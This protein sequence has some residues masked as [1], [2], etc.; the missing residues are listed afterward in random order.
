MSLLNWLPSRL[1]A[2]WFGLM[3][4]SGRRSEDGGK[5]GHGGG[6]ISLNLLPNPHF[7]FANPL[8]QPPL[9][10][11]SGDPLPPASFRL[12]VSPLFCCC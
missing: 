7:L 3:G 10:L 8:L 11:Q 6:G 2:N 9:S 5:G 12:E 4:S 1:G